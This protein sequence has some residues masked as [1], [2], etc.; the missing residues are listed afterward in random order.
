LHAATGDAPLAEHAVWMLAMLAASEPLGERLMRPHPLLCPWRT[1]PPPEALAPVLDAIYAALA[2]PELAAR[3]WAVE[4]FALAG[5]LLEPP[6]REAGPDEEPDDAGAAPPHPLARP[7]RLA[8]AVLDAEVDGHWLRGFGAHPLDVPALQAACASRGVGW[9]RMAHALWKAWHGRGC[10]ADAELLFAP[11]G[12]QHRTMWPH[13]PSEVLASLWSRWTSREAPWPFECFGPSQWASFLDLFGARWRRTAHSP[14]WRTAVDAMTLEQVRLAVAGGALL[15][16]REPA[17]RALVERVARR[18]P[19]WLA[20]ALAEH[21]DAGDAVAV[22]VLLGS[23]SAAGEDALL[24]TLTESLARRTTQRPVI[25]VARR[26][27]HEK[28]RERRGD[29]RRAYAVF[30]DLEERLARAQRARG[31]PAL[32]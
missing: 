5:R 31:L 8:E 18:F 19:G 15:D 4:A 13:L 20:A 11:D 7:A 26:Y 25:D 21:A 27:L 2:R 10:P 23:A 16:G 3:P 32:G 1:P 14:L 29:W 6:P 9:P 28:I 17:A 22:D 30:V 12:P 24:A